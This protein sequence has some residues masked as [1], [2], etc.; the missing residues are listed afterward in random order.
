MN[1][2]M[3]KP[4][5]LPPAP[6]LPTRLVLFDGVCAVC[7]A[8]MTW[9]LDHDPDGRFTYAP[10]QGPTAATVLARHPEL[11]SDLD[12]ILYVTQTP[13][14]ERVTTHST[15]ILD[16][17]RDLGGPWAWLSV[18]SV[19]PAFLRDPFYRAFAAIRYRVFGKRDS[20]RMPTP[21]EAARFLP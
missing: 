8:G 21:E 7:D 15:A 1:A 2:P 16:I 20:C 11:P 9:L 17:A 12:T 10:L 6:P 4:N 19:V 13:G 5:Q 14:G 3:P 18:A